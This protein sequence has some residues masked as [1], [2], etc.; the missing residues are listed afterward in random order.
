MLGIYEKALPHQMNWD[1][2]L[3]LAK[4]LGFDFVEISVDESDERLARLDWTNEEI[5]SVHQAI[6][7]NDI[8]LLSMCLSGHRRFPLGSHSAA[9][10][11]H[12][13]MMMKKAIRL[14]SKLGIRNIQLAGYD[15]YYEDKSILTRQLFI[16]NLTKCVQM[17]EKYEVMLSIEIM[18]DP[19]INSISKVQHLKTLIHSPWLQ[20]YPDIG[21][22]TA[23]PENDVGYELEH[24]IDNIAAVH[25]KD[26]LPVRDDFPGKFK[27]VPFG[28]G[29]VDFV[30]ALKMLRALGYHG[31]YMIE[32]WSE[33]SSDPV[34]EIKNAKAF[35]DGAFNK[36]EKGVD[37]NA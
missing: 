6:V 17:A 26:T 13:L 2:K 10:R 37:F 21:N 3:A 23:W 9:T 36:A 28:D 35:I 15:V 32:M 30:G 27:N 5:E 25:L 34:N 8:P 7:K 22:L 24:G 31:P 18:D 29:T 11:E 20:A 1:E 19:F 14:A 4:S 33:N 12:A 16:E